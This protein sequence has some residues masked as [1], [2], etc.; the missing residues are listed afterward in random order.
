MKI[1]VLVGIA[2]SAMAFG[3]Q[4][5]CASPLVLDVRQLTVLSDATLTEL[6]A[7]DSGS[8]PS[9][10]EQG[11][12]APDYALCRSCYLADTATSGNPL[13]L[14][15]SGLNLSVNSEGVKATVAW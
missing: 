4:A 9:M 5:Y 11:T 10:L 14:P 2:I 12:P 6:T 1:T 13:S 15:S 7:G 3:Q 8:D